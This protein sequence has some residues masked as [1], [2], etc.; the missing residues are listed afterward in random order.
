MDHDVTCSLKG[1]A[2][3]EIL[4]ETKI[5]KTAETTGMSSY[6]PLVSFY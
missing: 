6:V 3:S 4:E 5:A 1:G 2:Y